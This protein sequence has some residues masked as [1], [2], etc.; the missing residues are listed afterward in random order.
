MCRLP[1]AE[2][3]PATSE[4]DANAAF[5]VVTMAV[6]DLWKRWADL[7]AVGQQIAVEWRPRR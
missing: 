4:P 7:N 3:R 1:L 6:F 2:V 5:C